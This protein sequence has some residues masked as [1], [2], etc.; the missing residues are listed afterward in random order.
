VLNGLFLLSVVCCC[1]TTTAARTKNTGD[2][3]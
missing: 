3:P 1:T 2:T